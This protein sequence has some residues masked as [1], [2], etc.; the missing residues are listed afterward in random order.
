MNPIPRRPHIL[1]CSSWQSVNIGDIAH[2]PAALALLE[3]YFPEARVTLWPWKPLLDSTTHRLQTRFPDLRIVEG[4]LT[5]SGEP[6][7]P[8]LAQA[9]DEADFFLH[10]SGPA[11]L[12]YARAEAFQA[13]T[14]RGFGV[15]GVTYGLYGTPEHETLS[16]A[17]FVYLRDSGSLE[18]VKNEGVRAPI[19]EW[20]PDVAFG[21]DGRDDAPAAAFLREQGLE[22][23]EFLCCIPR[24]RNTPF[25]DLHGPGTPFDPEKH[26][27]N[28]AMKRLDHAPLVEAIIAVARQTDKKVLICPE[29]ESQIEL[30]R[31]V[32][33]EPLPDDVKARVVWRDHFWSPDEALSTYARSAGLFGCEMHSPIMCIGS[34]I[35]AIVC[36]FAEQSTKGLMWRDIGLGEWLFDLDDEGEK[37]R[38]APAVLQMAQDSEG[39]KRKARAAREVVFGRYGETMEVVKRAVL[40][41]AGL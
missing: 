39:A 16:R 28:Q 32:L 31:E 21:F 27:R 19:I 25:W 35:P 15:Y 10:S 9:M 18:R 7:T 8:D 6:A 5:E 2:T 40:S 13:R 24:Y 41:K 30:G 17:N 11:T 22:D 34:E 20:S 29:D 14:G 1:L 38:I 37:T 26:A 12:G 3:T 4:E 33:F 36:R 23:G